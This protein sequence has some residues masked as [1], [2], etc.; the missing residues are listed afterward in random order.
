MKTHIIQEQLREE[1]EA[2]QVE[3]SSGLRAKKTKMIRIVLCAP[4]DLFFLTEALSSRGSFPRLENF[5][6]EHARESLKD[7]LTRA[8]E[9]V[10][11]LSSLEK[12]PSGKA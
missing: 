10:S 8:E 2:I 9:M 6:E 5:L 12:S 7:Y 1:A 4:K 3:C 11:R